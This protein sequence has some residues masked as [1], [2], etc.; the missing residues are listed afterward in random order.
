MSCGAESF[1]HWALLECHVSKFSQT[2][3]D[4]PSHEQWNISYAAF[5]IQEKV[6]GGA[7]HELTKQCIGSCFIHEIE[8]M[9][10]TRYVQMKQS[11]FNLRV[12]NKTL[13]ESRLM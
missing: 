12:E 1:N 13:V 3:V 4:K 8:V 9:V 10:F 6:G 7:K 5:G 11:F 2:F